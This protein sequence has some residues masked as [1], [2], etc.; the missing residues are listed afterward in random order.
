MWEYE[1]TS[2]LKS[3]NVPIDVSD[4]VLNRSHV[5]SEAED[6]L[7]LNFHVALQTISIGT[8]ICMD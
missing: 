4:L 1:T 6:V 2:N 5:M 3:V 8:V 7:H